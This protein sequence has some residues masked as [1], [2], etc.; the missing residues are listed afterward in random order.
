[1]GYYLGYAIFGLIAGGV[2]RL[3][4]PG[5]DPMNWLWTMVLGIGG[6]LLGGYIAQAGGFDTTHGVV[7]WVAAIGG[8]VLLLVIHRMLTAR[9]AV[10]GGPSTPATGSGYKEAVFDDLSRGPNG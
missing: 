4:H 7:S 10:A 1:M 6:S 2:A 5:K 9:G 8:S 3:L